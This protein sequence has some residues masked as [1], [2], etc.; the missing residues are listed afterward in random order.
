MKLPNPDVDLT[1]IDNRTSFPRPLPQ[2]LDVIPEILEL[3][4][5]LT[6]RA[7]FFFIHVGQERFPGV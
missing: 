5:H 7:G 1:E 2:L 4:I 6:Y 3:E